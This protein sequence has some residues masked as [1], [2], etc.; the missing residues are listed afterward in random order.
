MLGG[1]IVSMFVS[2]PSA[3]AEEVVPQR[4]IITHVMAALPT[5]HCMP[6]RP[7]DT[8]RHRFKVA[9]DLGVN[10]FSFFMSRDHRKQLD[11]YIKS[12]AK[13]AAIPDFS[14][15]IC[16]GLPRCRLE[17][18]WLDTVKKWCD[19][20][21]DNPGI[22][23]V[24]GRPVV[25]TYHAAAFKLKDWQAFIGKLHQQGYNPYFV[26][27]MFAFAFGRPKEY[28]AEVD[29]W[30]ELMDSLYMFGPHFRGKR[31]E[32]MVAATAKARRSKS[33]ARAVVGTVGGGYWRWAT[34]HQGH[35]QHF[36]GT[37]KYEDNWQFVNR[38]RSRID[39]VHLTTWNDY[40]EH[41]M[42]EPSRNN[43]GVYGELLQ[44]YGAEFK[45]VPR[46]SR[47]KYWL[48]AP[49]ELRNGP[50]G[51]NEYTYEVRATGLPTKGSAAV[52]LVFR[53][54]KGDVIR[55]EKMT[56]TAEQSVYRFDWEPSLQ[57][58]GQSHFITMNAVV[59]GAS[60]QVAGSLPILVWPADEKRT[61]YKAPRTLRLLAPDRIPAVPKLS[62]GEDGKFSVSPLPKS[63]NAD[64][65]VDI[66]YDMYTKGK[67]GV[68]RGAAAKGSHQLPEYEPY[69][70]YYFRRG[71]RQAALVTRDGRV[72]WAQ[73]LWV[74]HDLPEIRK[75]APHFD[76][77]KI[78][79]APFKPVKINFQPAAAKTP[80]GYLVDRG[81]P[82]GKR[83]N[84][85]FYGWSRDV[86]VYTRERKLHDEVIYDTLIPTAY[87]LSSWSWSIALPNGDYHL[88]L[89][90]GDAAFRTSPKL[91]VNGA[92]LSDPTPGKI[93]SDDHELKVTVSNHL[94]KLSGRAAINYLEITSAK[95]ETQAF[96]QEA[97]PE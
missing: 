72:G 73:P 81:L 8:W 80:A 82:F 33:G 25:W 83:H 96:L 58:F 1:G 57:E 87:N 48:T 92:R 2:Q 9:A 13:A 86:Q 88:K 79:S 54:D 38:N 41:T 55:S 24:E 31:F 39:W 18:D 60:G 65:R 17:R 68:N 10:E 43:S 34:D 47:E 29:Q 51:L 77:V 66:L 95:V 6:D 44:Q 3:M 12:A 59:A 64:Y 67:E 7:L 75:E 63:G 61:M 16:I 42:N 46:P 62:L 70:P 78:T 90:L 35:S 85:W 5:D 94:L 71:F 84:G 15:S 76:L 20:A 11:N 32:A 97:L 27:D 40:L 93:G 50:G 49:A 53:N 52:D 37:G 74:D 30:A 22:A 56:L 21:K 14:I 23:K 19:A 91:T 45:G 36:D 26:G 69:D 4:R 28:L 89:G